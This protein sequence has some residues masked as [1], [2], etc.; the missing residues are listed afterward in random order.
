MA[1]S[2][3]ACRSML[4]RIALSSNS[5]RTYHSRKSASCGFAR[6]RSSSRCRPR[7]IVCSAT[8][9]LPAGKILERIART[10]HEERAPEIRVAIHDDPRLRAAAV[11][12]LRLRAET[13]QANLVRLKD[14]L[15]IPADRIV[16]LTDENAGPLKRAGGSQVDPWPRSSW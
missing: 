12:L 3:G 4:R 2:A 16:T 5:V 11:G 10:Q 14:H 7:R 13:L 1:C 6:P 9:K 8:G 15:T